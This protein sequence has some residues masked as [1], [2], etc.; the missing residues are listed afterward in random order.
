MKEV[1]QKFSAWFNLTHGRTGTLWEDRFRS[2]L[3]EGTG[4][5]SEDGLSGLL[6][7][8]ANIDLFCC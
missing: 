6:A 2:V 7:V 3:V 4:G 5:Y 8:A 1:K